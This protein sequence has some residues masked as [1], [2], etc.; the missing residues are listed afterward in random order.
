[1]LTP[2]AHFTCQ[3][4]EYNLTVSFSYPQFLC[5]LM[6]LHIQGFTQLRILAYCSIYYGLKKKKIDA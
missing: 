3:K 6:Q 4:S 1:M 2:P 5:I